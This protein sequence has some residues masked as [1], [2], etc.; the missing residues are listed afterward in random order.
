MKV[1]Y[2]PFT[3]RLTS[4]ALLSTVGGDPNSARTVPYVPGSA[5][6]G[7]AAR[8]LVGA[9]TTAERSEIFRTIVL[10]GQVRF[11]SAYPRVAERRTL[12]TP[13]SLGTDRKAF[14]S[15][16]GDIR[17]QDLAAD[18]D[19][20]GPALSALTEPF[21]TLGA[22]QPV[23]V[24]PLRSARVHQQRD[25]SRGR[26]WKE[27]KGRQ[28]ISHGA[29]YVY[30]G[31]DA[32]Q[33]FD[34]LVQ[35]RAQDEASCD[36]LIA[37]V[38]DALSGPVLV[39]RS[40]RGGYGGDAELKWH[41]VKGREVQGLGFASEISKGEAFRVLLTSPYVGRDTETGQL[42]PCAVES[43][44]VRACE[45]RVKVIG[46]CWRF[47]LTGGFNRKWRLEAP[48]ALACAAGSVLLLEATAPLTEDD[49]LAVE[50]DG[51]GERRIEGLG[52]VAFLAAAPATM[53]IG[54]PRSAPPATVPPGPPPDL[55]R[56][57][58]E[59]LLRGEVR[60]AIDELAG[61]LART[62]QAVPTASLLARLRGALRA[63][64][65]R[66]LGTLN[67]WL[68]R[69]EEHALRRPALDQ[70]ERCRLE[71]GGQE[72]LSGWLRGVAGGWDDN[73]L[74]SLLRLEVIAQRNHIV[75]AQSASQCLE[76]QSDWMR[77]RLL[78]TTL[79]ALARTKRKGG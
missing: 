64:P 22:A 15:P 19:A 2:L 14:P 57:A 51:L 29:V 21:M 13:L 42:D 77:V 34:G 56:R 23:R 50:H 7:V 79:A 1:C 71:A 68:A 63:E 72:R 16:S 37:V 47:E 32:G 18:V 27:T 53:T 40:R 54:L 8:A 35:I 38:K 10:S 33:E 74:G 70:I 31:L 49:L 46:R 30:E 36:V 43:E 24:Q 58:E 17:A 26:A 6:R 3:M 78:D 69:G 62:A 45:G 52:R 60:R 28:E 55:V 73:R 5:L 12:P 59:R 61:R 39:G 67:L 44:I 75:S 76:A 9:D 4:S 66:A 11:L 20:T 65:Q 41:P 48:Q 25:R